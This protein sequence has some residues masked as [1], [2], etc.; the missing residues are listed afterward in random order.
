MGMKTE[1]YLAK[2]DI[3]RKPAVWLGRKYGFFRGDMNELLL[4]LLSLSYPKKREEFMRLWW[5]E[6]GSLVYVP[7]PHEKDQR[8]KIIWPDKTNKDYMSFLLRWA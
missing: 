8:I 7:E 2:N 5:I 3:F 4:L 6:F 1:Y